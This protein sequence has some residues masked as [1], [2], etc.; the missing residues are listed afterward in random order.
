[1]SVIRIDTRPL[2]ILIVALAVAC[3]GSETENAEQTDLASINWILP[4]IDGYLHAGSVP[5]SVS[6]LGEPPPSGSPAMQADQEANARALSQRASPRWRQATKDASLSYPEAT[7]DFACALDAPI[8]LWSTPTLY[9]ALRGCLD[10]LCR[11]LVFER[12]KNVVSC[13][14]DDE[15]S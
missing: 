14:C 10:V 2:L 1:M 12:I 9:P 15:R 8:S 6:L 4:F 5:S 11:H 7:A 3:A 13:H